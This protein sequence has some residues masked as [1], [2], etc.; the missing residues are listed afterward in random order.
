MS[1]EDTNQTET[2]DRQSIEGSRHRLRRLRPCHR[3]ISHHPHPGLDPESRRPRLRK[4]SRPRHAPPGPL[5]RARRRHCLRR[6]RRS[7]LRAGNQ[8]QLPRPQSRRNPHGRRTSP[9]NAS[10]TF[11]TRMAP[12]AAPSPSASPTNSCA[13]SSMTTPSNSPGPPRSSTSTA[14]WSSPSA[15]STSGSVRN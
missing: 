13:H 5:L 7:H 6:Q 2:I 4:Q 10:S 1:S 11:S 15:N 9:A 8:R 12:A 14:G 3:R